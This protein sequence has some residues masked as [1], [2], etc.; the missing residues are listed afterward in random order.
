MN[1]I[2]PG[3]QPGNRPR[4][5]PTPV[6]RS[7]VPTH[8]LS[9]SQRGISLPSGASETAPT[10]SSTPTS[11]SVTAKRPMIT[12]MK[13]TPESSVRSEERRVGKEDKSRGAAETVKKQK[14]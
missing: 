14:E 3:V 5:K 12:A 6:A 8:A 2:A 13:S 11:T 9:S 7:I 4:K 1:E 10:A